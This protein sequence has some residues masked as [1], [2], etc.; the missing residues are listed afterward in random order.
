MLVLLG[1]IAADPTAA[2]RPTHL[3]IAV[4]AQP[5]APRR[6]PYRL[7]PTVAAPADGKAAALAQTGADCDRIGRLSCTSKP[8]R[9]YQTSY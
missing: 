1:L 2:P 8:T 9:L 4:P 7:D 6:S 3:R 5:D